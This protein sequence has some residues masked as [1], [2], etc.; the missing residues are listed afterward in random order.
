MARV[1]SPLELAKVAGH[2]DLKMLIS[3]YYRE[4]VATLADR[5]G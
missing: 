3:V 2:K 1:L 4:D 5:L